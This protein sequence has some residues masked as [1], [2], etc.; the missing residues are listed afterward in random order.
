M[1]IAWSTNSIHIASCG[2]NSQMLIWD[3]N[4]GQCIVSQDE[5]NGLLNGVIWD[6]FG[7]YLAVQS[8]ENGLTVWNT[9]FLCAE[10]K[11]GEYL[12][13]S[14]TEQLKQKEILKYTE[15]YHGLQMDN[16]F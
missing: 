9:D 7:K 12:A 4:S 8:N 10:S 13:A 5:H 16:I 14:V 11:K 15:K 1:D 3:S 2:M 6:P